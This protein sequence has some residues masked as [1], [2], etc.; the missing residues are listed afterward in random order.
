[1][2]TITIQGRP[3]GTG[4]PVYI[5]AEMSA[6]H[7]HSYDS[8]VEILHAA[9][10]NGADA[11]KLQT[12]TPD[13]ITLN[14][15]TPD[16][17]VGKGSLWEGK[18]LYDLYGE[19]YMP[20]EWQPRLKLEADKIGIPL[21]SS[22]FDFS[23]VDFL[24]TMQVPAYKIAS[25]ELVDLPLIRKVAATGKP[26]IMSTGM[27]TEEEIHDAVQAAR[28]AGAQE[29]ALLKCTSAY[30]APP[31]E[32]NL[33]TIA[34]LA[35]TFGLPVGLSD[36][37]M[38][39][40]AAIASVALGGCI[41]EK[42]FTM[43]RSIPG[44]DSAFSLEPDEFKKMVDAIRTTEKTLGHVSYESSEKEKANRVFRRS[45]YVSAPIKAGE[46]F[47]EQN[48]RSVRPAH[49]LAPKHIGSILGKRA[50]CDLN[51]GTPLNWNLIK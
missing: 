1:M 13:T 39:T 43:S 44:P 47:T 40:L 34:H 16:F 29:L 27:A 22:P 17:M 9:Q 36:H 37:T 4:H 31:E 6:N 35:Q 14:C 19:A 30:P 25:F 12:Y 8:A 41:I 48:V 10:A 20:W 3:I 45:L 46:I 21:F 33:R 28:E 32:M 5:I 26:L 18:N 2:S 24:E 42:H 49:G 11:I 7:N 15:R 50:A 51:L 23:A 38:E